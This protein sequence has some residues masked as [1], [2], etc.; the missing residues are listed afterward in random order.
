M[1]PADLISKD[2]WKTTAVTGAI[3]AASTFGYT[4]EADAQHH[5]KEIPMEDGHITFLYDNNEVQDFSIHSEAVVGREEDFA[6]ISYTDLF[7]DQYRRVL[8]RATAD[9]FDLDA[10]YSGDVD[11]TE[12]ENLLSEYA[13]DLALLEKA[14][15]ALAGME[16]SGEYRFIDQHQE[17]YM[18][19][20]NERLA[21]HGIALEEPEDGSMYRVV[22]AR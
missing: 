13:E 12:T 15:E 8:E 17:L 18:G 5:R 3:V 14:E 10:P 11:I 9:D 19:L 2:W 16:D 20:V 4:A 21:E 6:D 7:G 1:E 22:P